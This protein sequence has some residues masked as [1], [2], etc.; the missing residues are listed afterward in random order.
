LLYLV[1]FSLPLTP[2]KEV[3]PICKTS[4]VSEDEVSETPVPVI[5]T[6]D[7]SSLEKVRTTDLDWIHHLQDKLAQA[8]IAHRV[9]IADLPNRRQNYFALYVRPEDL[10]IA[11]EIDAQVFGVEVPDAEGMPRVEDL[12]FWSC[13]AC[14]SRLGEKDLKCS[15]CGL[16]LFPTEGWRCNNCNGAV[17]INVA[18]CPHCGSQIDRSKP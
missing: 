8:G 11:R 2:D 6:D 16:V 14:G 5:L 7:L 4:L 13:P 1:P 10:P 15:N 12:D 3:C 18:V 17:K 9:E